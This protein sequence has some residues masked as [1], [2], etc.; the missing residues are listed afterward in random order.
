[1][2]ATLFSSPGNFRAFKAL[3]ASEYNEVSIAVEDFTEANVAMSPLGKAPILQTAQ[4][5][6]PLNG[7]ILPTLIHSHTE[8]G[9]RIRPLPFP[10]FQQA[11][12]L[13]SIPHSAVL[14]KGSN[15]RACRSAF[16]AGNQ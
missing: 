6:K 3:I 10:P 14:L 9:G 2:S 16:S 1:M 5:R 13:A 12:K 8:Q 4:V 7:T 15:S 11:T